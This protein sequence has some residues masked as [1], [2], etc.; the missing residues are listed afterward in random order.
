MII[1]VG[2]HEVKLSEPLLKKLDLWVRT[3]TIKAIEEAITLCL[4]E[5]EL[6]EGVQVKGEKV[7][8]VLPVDAAV[9]SCP[10][11]TFV[12]MIHTHPTTTSNPSSADLVY[13]LRLY[14]F[15]RAP[16]GGIIGYDRTATFYWVEKLPAIKQ[17]KSWEKAIE[18]YGLL[19][20]VELEKAMEFF[21]VVKMKAEFL[22]PPPPAP[23]LRDILKI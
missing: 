16:F 9:A 19:P 2:E 13:A 1:R 7:A 20:A 12:G 3:I 4:L 17:L 15:A 6:R 21:S 11:G 22:P 14:R 18:V 5:G 8:V 10:P 23:R